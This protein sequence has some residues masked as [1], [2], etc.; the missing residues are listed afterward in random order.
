MND[1]ASVDI[2]TSKLSLEKLDEENQGFSQ[3]TTRLKQIQDTIISLQREVEESKA[4]T[5]KWLIG[6]RKYTSEIA[7]RSDKASQRLEENVQSF[8]QKSE[9]LLSSISTSSREFLESSHEM[10]DKMSDRGKEIEEILRN[11]IKDKFADLETRLES[12]RDEH[13]TSLRQVS[14]SYERMHVE[15]ASI[16]DGS[17]TLED[18]VVNIQGDFKKSVE[19]LA[20]GFEGL[21]SSLDSYLEI[22]KRGM[23]ESIKERIDDIHQNLDNK[24]IEESN[25]INKLSYELDRQRKIS[26]RS[27]RFVWIGIVLVLLSAGASHAMLILEN[28]WKYWNHVYLFFFGK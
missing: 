20:E 26:K 11:Q 2:E 28:F 3:L 21:K 22:F 10:L 16:R 17:Q 23:E 9:A 13:M 12:F 4:E 15:Y 24:Y 18:T 14:K 25:R 19:E 7:E 8:E 1:E 5:E 6:H 27:F